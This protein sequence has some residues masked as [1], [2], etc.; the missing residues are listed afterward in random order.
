M[1]AQFQQ[2]LLE[3]VNIEPSTFNWFKRCIRR[4]MMLGSLKVTLEDS[5]LCSDPPPG[6]IPALAAQP[7]SYMK[8]GRLDVNTFRTI[9]DADV[10]ELHERPPRSQ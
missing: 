6:Y 4:Y 9:L 2:D 8:H 7:P 3:H 5:M 10:L 1:V